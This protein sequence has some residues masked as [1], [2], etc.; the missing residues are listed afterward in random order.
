M[1]THYNYENLKSWRLLLF[2]MFR[3]LPLEC[4]AL[5]VKLQVHLDS[6]RQQIVHHY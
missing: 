4:G 6:S 1:K 2:L 5:E 3:R